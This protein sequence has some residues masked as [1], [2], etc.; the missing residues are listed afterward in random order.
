MLI[1]FGFLVQWPT[2]VMAVLFPALVTIE[3]MLAKGEPET[4]EREFGRAW[5]DDAAKTPRFVPARPRHAAS[6]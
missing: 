2:L 1:M 6:F 4:S 3:V 5:R